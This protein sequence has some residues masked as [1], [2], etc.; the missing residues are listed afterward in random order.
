MSY[1]CSGCGADGRRRDSCPHCRANPPT[2][3]RPTVRLVRPLVPTPALASGAAAPARVELYR[4]PLSPGPAVSLGAVPTEHLAAAIAEDLVQLIEWSDAHGR[5]R[6]VGLV[7]T[8][9]YVVEP[10]P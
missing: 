7:P 3:L 8:T 6:R 1:R 10:A 2:A 5:G 9:G 4:C